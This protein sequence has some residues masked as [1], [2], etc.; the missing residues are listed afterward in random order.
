[1][2]KKNNAAKAA[3]KAA[4]QKTNDEQVVQMTFSED[5]FYKDQDVA[6]FEKGKTYTIRGGDQI[7]RW[8]KRGGKIVKGELTVPAVE[9]NSSTLSKNPNSESNPYTPADES[10]KEENKEPQGDESQGDDVD[11]DEDAGDSDSNNQDE[12]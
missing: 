11:S 3:A 6:H 2:S 4:A 12:T 7:Q 9:D 10:K 5:K 8:L 1:M